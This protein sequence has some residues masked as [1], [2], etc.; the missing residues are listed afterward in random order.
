MADWLTLGSFW[1]ATGAA[2]ASMAAVLISYVAM[3]A[4]LDPDVVVY[5]KHD[6]SRPSILTIVIENVGRGVA[7]DVQFSSSS[8]IPAR[9]FGIES[10][11]DRPVN[12][13]DRG[14]LITGIPLLAPGDRRVITWG[15]YGGL[16]DAI[17]RS[18]IAVEASYTR[19]L[20]GRRRRRK[21][22]SLEVASFESTDAS[23]PPEVSQVRELERIRAMLESGRTHLGT[24]ANVISR[25]EI[26]AMITRVRER[27]QAAA[28]I[29]TQT[30]NDDA[31]PVA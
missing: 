6:A 11:E 31:E 17:G 20:G 3:R 23:T 19:S 26:E 28:D 13:M 12:Y 1:V 22:Y 7:Y 25:P 15:Q 14:P 2:L 30:A 18:S 29:S 5:A 9:A 10:G 27:E 21:T 24:I 4:D 16:S 8:P